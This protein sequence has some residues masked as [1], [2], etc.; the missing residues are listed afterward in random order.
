MS[1]MGG[2]PNMG[3][4]GMPNMGIGMPNMGMG[5]SGM[6]MGMM[7]GM[8]GMGGVGMGGVS[9]MG[10]MGTMGMGMMGSSIHQKPADPE[11][12][13]KNAAAEA[14]KKFPKWTLYSVQ[15]SGM[16]AGDWLCPTCQNHN[17]ADKVKCNRCKAPKGDVVV[18][19]DDMAKGD[20]L[21]SKCYNH[22]YA[23]KERCNKCQMPKS[24]ASVTKGEGR[25]R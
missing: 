3:M 19:T 8:G 10:S 11:E 5:M 4:I 25:Y 20:W 22:N 1:M 14:E 9:G 21:C 7:N 12:A 2:M 23:D 16:R 13:E 18:H 24:T 17:Y 15:K 6:G